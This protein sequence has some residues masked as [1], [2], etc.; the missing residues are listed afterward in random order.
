MLVFIFAVSS[1]L[2]S[3][4]FMT[5]K[6]PPKK[7]HIN[8]L[9]KADL[10]LRQVKILPLKPPVASALILDL[11]QYKSWTQNKQTMQLS[12]PSYCSAVLC[13]IM[14]IFGILFVSTMYHN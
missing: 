10:H 3:H 7:S 11:R 8:K 1:K 5:N 13:D 14:N 12:C 4:K 2:F 9:K 6:S